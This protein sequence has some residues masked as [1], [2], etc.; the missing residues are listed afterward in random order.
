[1]RDF[2]DRNYLAALRISIALQ[3]G[4]WDM[5][6]K[7][8][9]PCSA[10]RIALIAATLPLGACDAVNELA[11]SGDGDEVSYH[12]SLGTSLSVGVQPDSNGVP[13]PT[14]DGYA[15]QLY[16]SIRAGFEAGGAQPR[17]LELVKLGCPGETLDDMINGGSCPYVAGSQLDAAVD[18]LNDNSGRIHLVTIDMGG[19]DFRNAGCIATTVDV[20]CVNAV[21]AQIATDLATV[22][23]TLSN[24]A[25]PNTTIVGMNYY[26]PYLGSWIVDAAGQTLATE[27]AQAAVI[28]NDLLSTTYATAGIPMAD[29]YAA[30]QSSDFATMVAS[31]LPPP[32]D[33]LPLSV[34]N[35][36]QFTYMCDASPVGPDIHANVAGYSLIADTIVAVLP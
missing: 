23:V 11:N 6:A 20:N 3:P 12:V 16:D 8:Y 18:F 30:F 27:S 29:V 4:A 9:T 31:S 10:L 22:L 5:K 24:A 34:A 36:C 15:D 17:D 21:S 33:V 1:M 32:N 28:F 2:V 19:N 25:G 35:I 13:L 26:N 7:S 14:D